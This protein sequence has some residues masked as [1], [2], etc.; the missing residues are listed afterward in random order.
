MDCRK[1]FVSIIEEAYKN[2]KRAIKLS[3]SKKEIFEGELEF[4]LEEYDDEIPLWCDLDVTTKCAAIEYVYLNRKNIELHSGVTQAWA[5]AAAYFMLYTF[6][7]PMSDGVLDLSI[8]FDDEDFMAA[9]DVKKLSSEAKDMLG[10]RED[11]SEPF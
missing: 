9:N 4:F 10:I 6:I 7:A 1:V 8:F 2:F 5:Q 11:F 3:N